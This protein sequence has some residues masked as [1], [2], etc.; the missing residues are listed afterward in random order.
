MKKILYTLTL[1]ISFSSFGQT[2]EDYFN[3]AIDK[4]AAND[5]NGAIVDYTK[6]IELLPEL[7]INV[8]TAY[9]NRGLSKADL[10]DYNGAIADYT[11]ALELNPNYTIAYRNRGISKE[12]LGD[13]NGACTDWKKAAELGDTDAA[14][15]VA[16]KCVNRFNASELL[17]KA[18]NKAKAENKNVFVKYNASWC[19]KCK[20]MDSK[21]KADSCK[22]M[23]ENNYVFV[24]LVVKESSKNK[25]L[26]TPGAIDFLKKH[27]GEGYGLPFW[28]VLN[29]NGDLLEDSFY[30]KGQNMGCPE[31]E[32]EVAEFINI[33][34]KTSNITK[35]GLD[36]IAKEFL[37]SN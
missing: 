21:M 9:N 14:G 27:N 30:I 7:D 16:N 17:E 24:S 1:L 5:F 26:E 4:D 6:A 23:F 10:K 36:V 20:K 25:Y 33:L 8:A 13:L 37:R 18:Y 19:G 15:W 3:S 12:S 31:S 29:K 35:E 11:K 34:R 2:A 28:V 22:S 32:I